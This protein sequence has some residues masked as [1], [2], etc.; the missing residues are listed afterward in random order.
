[1]RGD[2][3][4]NKYRIA[5]VKIK[6]ILEFENPERWVNLMAEIV[7]VRMR[8]WSVLDSSGERVTGFLEILCYSPHFG[9]TREGSCLP[10]YEPEFDKDEEFVCFKEIT[11]QEE[12]ADGS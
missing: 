6:A 1:M 10:I 12:K 8:D 11:E 4:L 9:L 2:M 3:S 5:S 7:P